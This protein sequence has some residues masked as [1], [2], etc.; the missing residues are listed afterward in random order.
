MYG[1]TKKSLLIEGQL[2]N[3]LA[4]LQ[5]SNVINFIIYGH[6]GPQSFLFINK[7]EKINV[8]YTHK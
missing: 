6:F 8:L 4:I 1:H 2:T 3:I 7:N 5:Q